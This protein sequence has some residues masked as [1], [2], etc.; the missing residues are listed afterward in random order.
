MNAKSGAAAVA[1]TTALLL[2]ATPPAMARDHHHH[3]HHHRY[4]HHHRHHHRIGAGIAG[5]AAGAIIGGA[6]AQHRDY[7][8]DYYAYQ[9]GPSY[10]QRVRWCMHHYRS[11]DLRTQTYMGYDGYRHHCP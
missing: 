2:T 8:P 1:A 9:P 7:G 3:R 4:H 11:Y 5:F 6:L 10:R